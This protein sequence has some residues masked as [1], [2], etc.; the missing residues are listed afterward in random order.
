VPL[1][2]YVNCAVVK[3]FVKG[4]SGKA[5]GPDRFHQRERMCGDPESSFEDISER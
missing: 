1:P 3:L 4:K 5:I 2:E